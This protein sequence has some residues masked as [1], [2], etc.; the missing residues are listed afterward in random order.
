MHIR[1][2]K[3]GKRNERVAHSK[4]SSDDPEKVD[5]VNLVSMRGISAN[6]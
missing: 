2:R 6:A 4:E 1:S 3:T 5:A